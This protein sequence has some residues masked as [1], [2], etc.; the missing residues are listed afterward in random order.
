[1]H[2][3]LWLLGLLDHPLLKNLYLGVRTEIFSE[4]RCFGVLYLNFVLGVV[5]NLVQIRLQLAGPSS[6]RNAFFSSAGWRVGRITFLCV[7]NLLL[8]LLI[9][10]LDVRNILRCRIKC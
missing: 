1:M 4:L 6:W 3:V 5:K 9:R 7:T 10:L 8:F 2:W